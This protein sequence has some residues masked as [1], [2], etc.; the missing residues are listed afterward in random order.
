MTSIA[1]TGATGFVGRSFC[2]RA[3][4]AGLKTTAIGRDEIAL[5]ELPPAVTKRPVKDFADSALFARQLEDVEIVVHLADQADRAAM[6][7]QSRSPNLMAGVISA[8]TLAGV[9][10]IVFAS[11]IYASLD[12][13]GSCSVYGRGK[14]DAEKILT[15]TEP[16]RGIVLRLPPVYGPGSAGSIALLSRVIGMY[17]PMPFKKATAPRDYLFID[18]LI[19]LMLAIV[20]SPADVRERARNRVFEPSDGAA[21]GTARLIEFIAETMDR[22]VTLFSFPPVLLRALAKA[23]GKQTQIDAAFDP[24]IA[25]GN[26]ELSTIFGWKPRCQMP[27]SLDFL[28][29]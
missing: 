10:D 28:R 3:A 26:E 15:D 13:Q 24:M 1:V 9:T 6:R 7:P 2:V 17:L 19:D 16:L 27:Q 20:S 11:S 8:A 4:A 25:A 22:N 21:V 29:P 23:V 18:N 12:E 14:R 5:G